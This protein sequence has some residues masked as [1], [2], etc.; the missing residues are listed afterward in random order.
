MSVCVVAGPE[1]DQV[2]LDAGRV[3]LPGG[4]EAPGADLGEG[5]GPGR[6]QLCGEEGVV[7]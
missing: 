6:Q 5:Q 1:L 4:P 3:R 2:G 7:G